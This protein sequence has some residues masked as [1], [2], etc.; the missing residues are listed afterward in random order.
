MRRLLA[1]AAFAVAAGSLGL[2]Y[3]WAASPSSQA[4]GAIVRNGP[5]QLPLV[6]LTFD[7]GP[8]PPWS[9]AIADVLERYGVRGAF[10]L[11]GENV[12]AYPEVA[13][14]LAARGHLVADHSYRHRKRDSLLDPRYRELDRA[15]EAIAEATGLC[16]ALYRP[17]NGFH[18]PWQ[19][20]TVAARGMVTVGWDV[21]PSDWTETSAEE[22][23]RRVLSSARPGSI[24]LLHDGLDTRHGADRSSTLAAL[25]GIIEG[26]QARGL[27]PVRLDELLAVAPYLPD[28]PRTAHRKGA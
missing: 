24:I 2:A 23:V 15:Q 21:Q 22:L 25:P 9:L 13:Q 5:R 1:L 20:R 27:H 11:V 19:L 6:A 3:Y 14:Q 10:F 17:P 7:D 8:N 4:Y 12:K 28:C 26:L 18:T 16:P